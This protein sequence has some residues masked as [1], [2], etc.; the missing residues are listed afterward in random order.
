M[1]GVLHIHCVTYP[2]TSEP[3]MMI[4]IAKSMRSR[5]VI[6]ASGGTCL[7]IIAR[8][9]EMNGGEDLDPAYATSSTFQN[10]RIEVTR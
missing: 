8:N 5:T 10:D 4:I 9:K 3:N 1:S 7:P 2:A 6:Y